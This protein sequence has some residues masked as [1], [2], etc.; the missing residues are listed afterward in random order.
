IAEVLINLGFRVS[1]SDLKESDTTRR[2]KKMGGTLYS[3]H[4]VE[5]LED[6]D[7]V[8]ISSAVKSDNPEVVEAH[9]R[10][11]PV[12]PRAEMLA[13]LMR[14]KR[15]IAVAGTHGKTTTT[16]MIATILSKSDLD[17]T[18]VIGGKLDSIGSNAKLGQGEYLVAEADESDG[19]FLYL[20]PTIS[21]VTNIDPEHLDHYGD[22]D[23]VM[24]T[25][26]DF[27]NK[28]PFYGLSVLCMDNNNVQLLLPKIKKRF[29]TFGLT[30]QADFQATDLSFDGMQ[31][32]F[33]VRFKGETLGKVTIGMPGIHNVYNALASIAVATEMETPFSQIQETLEGFN[34]IQR[35]FQVKGEVGGIMVVDD[36]GH[37]PAEIK[38]TLSA[39]KEGWGRR[40]VAVFQPHR[41]SRT[42]D[43]FSDFVTVFNEADVLIITDIYAAGEAPI[44]GISGEKLFKEIERHGH[45]DV[46]YVADR[47]EIPSLLHE[48]TTR[49]DIVITLGAGNIW[50]A[51]ETFLQELKKKMPVKLVVR[52][53][54]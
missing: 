28:V 34:G 31:T 23:T 27:I 32:S 25:Y 39:A 24:K 33:V 38:P 18:V 30:P 51:G 6:V 1:G 22:M 7:V 12:I 5:N 4:R 36:Y 10:L 8:V 19:S 45:R 14:L 40:V 29:V 49:G 35:R 54:T 44:E 43:L 50:E 41:Y 20:S 53:Q 3:G 15:G 21:V 37:H 13:E 46:S 52:G 47:S 11:T 16:S 17:P 26:L 42:R 48:K 9:R 2:L